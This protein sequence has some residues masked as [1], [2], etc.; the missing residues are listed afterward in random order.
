MFRSLCGVDLYCILALR[1]LLVAVM[2]M[3]ITAVM[4][5]IKTVQESNVEVR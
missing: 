1:S 5:V 4:V 3:A 2:A